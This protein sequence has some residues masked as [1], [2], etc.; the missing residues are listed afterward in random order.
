MS[1]IL[2]NLL[3]GPP[4]FRLALFR[5]GETNKGGPLLAATTG[6]GGISGAHRESSGGGPDVEM[7]AA[8]SPHTS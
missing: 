2:I 3:I 5:V 8:V 4:L 6:I 1:I 7:E